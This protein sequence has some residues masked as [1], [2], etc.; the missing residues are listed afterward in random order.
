MTVKKFLT[1]RGITTK[2]AAELCWLGSPNLAQA[3]ER[4]G[5]TVDFPIRGKDEDD[6][7][8][9]MAWPA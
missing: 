1:T 2:Q 5:S 7:E 6:V 3:G 8:Y 9:V 4:P